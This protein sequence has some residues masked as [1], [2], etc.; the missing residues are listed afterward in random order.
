MSHSERP[1]ASEAFEAAVEV[2]LGAAAVTLRTA[3]H[4]A[5]E[6]YGKWKPGAC[7]SRG[8]LEDLQRSGHEVR[9]QIRDFVGGLGSTLAGKSGLAR[10]AELEAL[11]QQ[12]SRLE[13]ELAQIRAKQQS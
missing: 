7:R 12:V 4:A 5:R 13:Q 6:A 1:K 9:A 8:L 10:T 2:A 11:R 3:G